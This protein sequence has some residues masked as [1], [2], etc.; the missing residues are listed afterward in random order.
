M[1]TKNPQ[2]VGVGGFVDQGSDHGPITI[3]TTIAQR[4]GPCP[5]LI[6]RL[7]LHGNR[8]RCDCEPAT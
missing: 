1:P 4:R 6:G 2:P 5:R 8:R 3:P 7:S